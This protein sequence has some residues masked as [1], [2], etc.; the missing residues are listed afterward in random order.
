MLF[1]SCRH[2]FV[3]TRCAENYLFAYLLSFCEYTQILKAPFSS[4]VVKLRVYC[5]SYCLRF[6]C[7]R[8]FENYLFA[9]LQGFCEYRQKKSYLFMCGRKIK[10]VLYELLPIAIRFVFSRC[11][12]NY[13]FAKIV[14]NLWVVHAK[15]RS[16]L[17]VSGRKSSSA[18][19]ELLPYDCF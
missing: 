1:K 4:V 17:S 16:P 2:R 12:E 15:I 5:T 13:L 19:N 18:L 7:T 11:A 9:K 3:C 8:C 14:V 10:N 6:V